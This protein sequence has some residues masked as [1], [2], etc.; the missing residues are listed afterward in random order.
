MTPNKPRP[1]GITLDKTTGVLQITWAD[2]AAC[3]YPLSQLREACPCVECRGGHS[4]MGREFDPDNILVLIPKRSY[5]IQTLEM[6]G[7]YAFQPVWDDG[8]HTGIYTWEYL[9]RLCPPDAPQGD[10]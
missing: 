5:K 7:N 1:T 2:G 4:R 9:R 10:A 6:V 3:D 8:H